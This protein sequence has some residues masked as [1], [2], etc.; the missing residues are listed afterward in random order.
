M[1]ARHDGRVGS[2]WVLCLNSNHPP[3]LDRIDRGQRPWNEWD[4]ILK[5]VARSAQDNNPEAS[6]R[7]V[8]LKLQVLVAGQEYV[9]PGV[10]RAGEQHT[11][12]QSR[13]RFLLDRTRVVPD[14]VGRKLARQLLI[15][16]NAHG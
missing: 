15:E 11:I 16:Q 12:L 2:I 1:I 5:R 8:L 13:P 14:Q 4:Q 10:L 9:E 7:D 6:L 3:K